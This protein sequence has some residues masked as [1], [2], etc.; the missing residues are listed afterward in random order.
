MGNGSC[1]PCKT[2]SALSL[3][4]SEYSVWQV[5]APNELNGFVRIAAAAQSAI[6]I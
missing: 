4:E 6:P 1:L 3:Y 2:E 5:Q